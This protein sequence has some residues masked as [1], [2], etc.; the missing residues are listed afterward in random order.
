MSAPSVTAIVAEMNTFL[1][2]LR[3]ACQTEI[4]NRS[5]SPRPVRFQ[6]FSRLKA[7]S[8]L[9]ALNSTV[10]SG[11]ETRAITTSAVTAAAGKSRLSTAGLSPDSSTCSMPIGCLAMV[12]EI[13]KAST[14]I[15]VCSTARAAALFRSRNWSEATAISVS[16]EV[17]MPP[18]RIK[19]IP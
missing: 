18:P 9:K 6:K 12:S 3:V 16:I 11:M 7:P 14:V 1:R 17:T 5:R 8:T 15:A 10:N 13:L 19:M 4:F 2:V